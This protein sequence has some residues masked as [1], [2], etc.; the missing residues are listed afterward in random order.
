M[1]SPVFSLSDTTMGEH[2]KDMCAQ[3]GI[4]AKLTLHSFR[5]GA[6]SEAESKGVERQFIKRLGRWQ[7]DAM[8]ALYSRQTLDSYLHVARS[9]MFGA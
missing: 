9:L 3:A 5:I 8:P 7:S 6:A 1:G 2:L 4:T